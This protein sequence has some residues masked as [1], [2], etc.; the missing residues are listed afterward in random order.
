MN[1]SKEEVEWLKKYNNALG[2][3]QLAH[4]TN[5]LR[6]MHPPPKNLLVT[7]RLGLCLGE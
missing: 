4:G 6:H 5:L 3:F 7:V 1:L 2:T